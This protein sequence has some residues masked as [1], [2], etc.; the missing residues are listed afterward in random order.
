MVIVVKKDGKK[1][2][3]IIEKLVVSLL[4]VGL[5]IET[6]RKIAYSIYGKIVFRNQVESKELGR[7][8]LENLK[9]ID[10]KAYKRWVIFN[11]KFKSKIKEQ[12]KTANS[13]L[14]Q[15]L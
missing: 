1:E 2:E 4:R 5:D 10:E 13:N 8:I 12:V 7:M 11:R 6:A 3:F 14:K 9:K 15:F